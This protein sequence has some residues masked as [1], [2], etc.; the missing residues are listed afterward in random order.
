MVGLTEAFGN[1]VWRIS[2]KVRLGMQYKHKPCKEFPRAPS[3]CHIHPY[4]TS[5]LRV[6]TSEGGWVSV[7]QGCSTG[8]TLTETLGPRDT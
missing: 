1:C 4:T 3:I 6:S 7:R 5:T 8:E 2:L